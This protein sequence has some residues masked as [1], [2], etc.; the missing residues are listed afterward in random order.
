MASSRRLQN[1]VP[2][3][4]IISQGEWAPGALEARVE[5]VAMEC[6]SQGVSNILWAYATMGRKP[7]ERGLGAL[8]ARALQISTDFT[9]RDIVD[10][11]WAF[12]ELG[13]LLSDQLA[14]VLSAREAEAGLKDGF[15]LLTSNQKQSE[16]GHVDVAVRLLPH[17]PRGSRPLAAIH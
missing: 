12:S 15:K 3:K 4:I 1:S 14:A 2:I 5:E 16:R 13:L 17:P 10:T 7:E 11:R 9:S 6:N 8:E